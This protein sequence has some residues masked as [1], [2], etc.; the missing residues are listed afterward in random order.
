[1]MLSTKSAFQFYVVSIFFVFLLFFQGLSRRED[2]RIRDHTHHFRGNNQ[3]RTRDSIAS[4][5]WSGE[6]PAIETPSNLGKSPESM[7]CVHSSTTETSNPPHATV[8]VISRMHDDDVSWIATELP[9]INAA[10][11][12]ANDPKMSLHPP[13]NK[14]HEVM[15]Y[16]SYIIDHYYNLPDIIIFMHAHRWTHHNNDLLG[17]DAVRMI[18]RLRSEH[19]LREGYVNMRCHWDPG[20]PEWLHPNET[21][22]TLEKQE[23]G[24][25]SRIWDELFPLDTLPTVLGQP[26]CSQFALSNARVLSIPLSRFVFYRDWLLRTPLSD[27]ISGRIWEYIWQYV[28]TAGSIACP[29]EHICYCEAFG[30][31]FGGSAE[32]NDFEELRRTRKVFELELGK[33]KDE[34]K[35]VQGGYAREKKRVNFTAK[36]RLQRERLSY[37]SDHINALGKELTARM[38]NATERGKSWGTRIQEC[39]KQWGEGDGI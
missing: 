18:K 28:F 36:K 8:L 13:Q 32:Y 37:L 2:S 23:E 38:Q 3:S 22:E 20:C 15:I 25:V 30:I 16:L 10:I 39:N 11:Y 33:L 9:H 6:T 5:N 21:K 31:C 19:V 24:F 12:V 1:M 14:G 4:P 17:F 27:Y 35:V 7:P 29:A 26:C 34:Q